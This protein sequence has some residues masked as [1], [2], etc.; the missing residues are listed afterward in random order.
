MLLTVL[1]LTG[2]DSDQTPTQCDYAMDAAC[3]R[4]GCDRPNDGVMTM[5]RATFRCG[6][7]EAS[8]DDLRA[9]AG[10]VR[11]HCGTDM[12]ETTPILHESGEVVFV[13][14]GFVPVECAGIL[15]A[16]QP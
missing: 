7:A 10:A 14:Q 2:C 9:C 8:L 3:E 4:C 12:V 5:R 11:S 15:T 1:T 6:P 16:D 13:S